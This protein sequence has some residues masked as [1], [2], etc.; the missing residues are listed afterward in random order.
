MSPAPR[1]AP[2]VD[3]NQKEIVDALEKIGCKVIVIGRPVDLLV[4]YRAYNFLI[5]CKNP[6]TRYGSKDESTPTQ[7][8]FFTDWP[9]QVRKVWSAEEAI[10]L[11]TGAYR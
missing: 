2:R 6:D 11:V 7:R 4:G 9:G 10:K 1:Y 5:E 8:Q 3:E